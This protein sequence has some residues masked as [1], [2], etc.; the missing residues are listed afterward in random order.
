MRSGGNLNGATR[1]GRAGRRS[2]LLIQI[3]TGDRACCDSWCVHIGSKRDADGWY[4]DL[5]SG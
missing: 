5:C 3:M 1:F 2:L 4:G